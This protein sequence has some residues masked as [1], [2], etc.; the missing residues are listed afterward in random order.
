MDAFFD[1]VALSR[2]QFALTAMFHIIWPVA[3]IGLSIFLVF[4]GFRRIRTGREEYYHHA[5]FWSRLFFLNVAIGVATGIP[6]EFQFG[7]NWSVFARAGGDFFGHMLGYE[8]AMAFMLEA[9][10]IGIMIFGWKRVSPA[11]HLFATSMVALGASLSA[12]WIM[13]A[14]SWMQ[15][16]RGGFFNGGKFIVTSHLEAIFNP[17]MVW[18]VTHMWV[19]ALEISVFVIGGLSAWYLAKDR[20]TSFFLKSFKWAAVAAILITPL[21][22]VLGDGSGRAA[23]LYDPTKLAAFESHWHTNP[24]GEGA[25][26]SVLAWPDPELQDNRWSIE[27][28]A[29]LSLL[30]T[31]TLTGQIKGLRDFPRSDQPPVA[32]PYYAFRIMVAIGTALFI[33]MLWTLQVWRR[34]GLDAGRVSAQ[35]W[36]LRAWIAAIPLSYLAME[37]GWVTREVGR[38]PWIIHGMLRTGEAASRIPAQTVAA[39]LFAFALVYALLAILFFLFAGRIIARGPEL[40]QAETA[41]GYGGSGK[42]GGHGVA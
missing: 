10:F 41:S 5:R 27:I 17:D 18:S 16:P 39:S 37:T 31:H 1:T 23:Y 25:S 28:P 26:F 29:M 22:I 21:Q 11:A 6:M 34:G 14:N 4:L 36:L 7:T 9:S 19:A 35:K 42:E 2:V 20:Y 40:P 38:Q 30:T 3:T 15:T 13:V 8:A 33:L 12:F 32:I 24:P